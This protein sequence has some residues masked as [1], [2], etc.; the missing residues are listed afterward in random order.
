MN[1]VLCG[2]AA[3]PFLAGV[4]VAG[5]PAPLTDSQM[6]NVTAGFDFTELEIQNTGWVGVGVN[7]PAPVASGTGV[8][9]PYLV[10]TNFWYNPGATTGAAGIIAQQTA[11]GFGP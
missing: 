8:T 9:A 6:D 1:R 11:V 7:A 10:V 4:A 3:L 5:Q 2:L